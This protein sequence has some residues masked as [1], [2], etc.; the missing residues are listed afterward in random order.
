MYTIIFI[1]TMK[2]WDFMSALPFIVVMLMLL[3]RFVFFFLIVFVEI[4]NIFRG[5]FFLGC[6]LPNFSFYA[7]LPYMFCWMT[8]FSTIFTQSDFSM[9]EMWKGIIL[10]G[11]KKGDELKWTIEWLIQAGRTIFVHE[12]NSCFSVSVGGCVY[13]LNLL[14]FTHDQNGYQLTVI[15]LKLKFGFIFY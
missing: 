2:C 1:L 13:V 8:F 9:R 4:L 15:F 10:D 12:C 14:P 11:E 7:F 5:G 6:F 3:F